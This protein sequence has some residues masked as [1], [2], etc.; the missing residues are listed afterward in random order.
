MNKLIIIFLFFP[1]FIFAG[2]TDL[3]RGQ[4]HNDY[5]RKNPLFEALEWG[6]GSVEA[7][8]WY[9]DGKILVSHL[10]VT[11]KGSLEDLYLKPLQDIVNQ[12]GFIQ[13]SGISF[14]FWVDIK[15]NNPKL[16]STLINIL[17]RYPMLEKGKAKEAAVTIILTGNSE[18]KR[19]LA[20]ETPLVFRDS[21]DF[22]FADPV[23]DKSW[24]WYALNWP[25][26]VGVVVTNSD[27]KKLKSIVESIH[28]KGR[29]VRFWGM[30]KKESIWKIAFSA[31]VDQISADDI[32][33][34]SEF[35]K[36]Q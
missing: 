10:G 36:N 28:A 19:L 14:Y 13:K 23:D 16:R 7:D 5:E 4:S 8:I 34:L 9:R 29:K 6:I 24:N 2:T 31:G 35:L 22:S 18:A 15:D 3:L 27:I 11:F 33:R 25:K 32:P 21:N 30:P 17:G 12:K 1:V 20:K 26:T